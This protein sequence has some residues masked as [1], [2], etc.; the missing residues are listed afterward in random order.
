M[1]ASQRRCCAAAVQAF[2]QNGANVLVSCVRDACTAL[3]LAV[4][5]G[6]TDSCELL[7]ASDNSLIHM[8][9]SDGYTVLIKAAM[10]AAIDTV[11]LLIR[12]GADINAVS[13]DNTTA[14]MEACRRTRFDVA[15]CLLKAGADVHVADS[16]GNNALTYAVAANSVALV[17]LLLDHGADI[18]ATNAHG[19]NAL[20]MAACGGYVHMMELL[21]QCGLSVLTSVDDKGTTPL[22]TATSGGHAAAVEWLLQRGVPV[23][24]VNDDN[25]TALYYANMNDCDDPAIA[26]LLLANGADVHIRTSIGTTVLQGAA[27]VGYTECAKV[28][29]NAGVDVNIAADNGMSALHL[30]VMHNHSAVA[31]LLLEHGATAV[32]NKVVD[33]WCL[34][35]DYYCCFG[36][37]ALTLCTTADTAKVLLAADADVHVTTTAGDTCLHKAAGHKVAVSVICLLIKA[38]ADLHAVNNQGK[39]AAQVAHDS[40]NVLAEQLLVRAAQQGR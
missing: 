8:K 24:A 12:C 26:E 32:L 19:K 13:F 4:A 17:Q 29:I 7:L 14:L 27:I 3:H 11:Q 23:N 34:Q 33:I 6:R 35:S 28:F 31:Q 39:T 37:R 5:A 36:L 21:V 16:D 10:S 18:N 40:G 15:D 22:M 9:D 25:F 20:F 2:L 30:A 1:R 38:G